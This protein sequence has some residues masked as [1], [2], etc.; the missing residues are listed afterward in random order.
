MPAF[1]P[2]KN[3]YDLYWDMYLQ[4]ESVMNLLN[5]ESSERDS[6]L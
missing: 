1:D 2:K 4:N 5:T 6:N 3:Y